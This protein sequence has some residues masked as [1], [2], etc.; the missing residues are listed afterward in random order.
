MVRTLG[1]LAF[2]VAMWTGTVLPAEAQAP[3]RVYRGLFGSGLQGLQQSLVFN[4]AFGG[5]FDTNVISAEPEVAGDP[6]V[7][8][9][10]S[11]LFSTAVMG[12]G[13]NLNLSRVTLQARGAGNLSYYTTR[14]EAGHQDLPRVRQLYRPRSGLERPSR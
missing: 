2:V 10:S 9:K 5:G 8:S 12:L 14:R 3:G 6:A 1:V 4:G 11:G 13:Y 7:R